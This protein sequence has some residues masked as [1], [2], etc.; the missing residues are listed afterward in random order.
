M[1]NIQ[2]CII[3]LAMM[4]FA[5]QSC[6]SEPVELIAPETRE[7]IEGEEYRAIGVDFL[8]APDNQEVW[9]NLIWQA[10]GSWEQH[11]LGKVYPQQ[12]DWLKVIWTPA[13]QRLEFNIKYD[14]IGFSSLSLQENDGCGLVESMHIYDDSEWYKITYV[15]ND[16]FVDCL[17]D[18]GDQIKMD[19]IILLK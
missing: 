12:S 15:V 7:R 16:E 6:T 4:S 3:L 18:T 8:I 1:N 19:I 17:E 11:P 14:V 13:A 2:F 10:D 5:M 9:S